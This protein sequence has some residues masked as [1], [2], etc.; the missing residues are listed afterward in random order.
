MVWPLS[1]RTLPRSA[2]RINTVTALPDIH[3][4]GARVMMRPP[5]ASDWE[6]WAEVRGRNKERL[7]RYEPLWAPDNLTQTFFQ[8]RLMRQIHDWDM[9]LSQSFLIFSIDDRQ[10]IGGM[11]INNICRGAAQFASLGYWICANYE[12][13]GLMR[14]SVRLTLD[15]GFNTLKLHRIH[16]SC[17]KD[18][19]KSQ[20]VL[21]KSG[22]EQEGYAKNYLQINGI[23]QDHILFGLYKERYGTLPALGQNM[24][25]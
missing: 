21:L 7:T 18:N 9:G 5:K 16:A 20:N 14:E 1:I 22:F 2:A 3:L 8:K 17:L 11:N 19:T 12:G 6:D 13:R 4:T 25:I 10:L 15:H 23:W 24:V